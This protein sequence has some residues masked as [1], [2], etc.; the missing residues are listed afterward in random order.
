MYP[1]MIVIIKI[2][3]FFYTDCVRVDEKISRISCVRVD[4]KN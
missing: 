2:I 3:I 4:K 1:Y